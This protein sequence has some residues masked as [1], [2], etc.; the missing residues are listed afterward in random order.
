MNRLHAFEKLPLTPEDDLFSRHPPPSEVV[1]IPLEDLGKNDF[2]VAVVGAGPAG[3]TAALILAGAGY[4]VFMADGAV[5]PR[6]KTCGDGLVRDSMECLKRAGLLEWLDE[7]AFS[8]RYLS[9]TSRKGTTATGGA[10]TRVLQRKILDAKLADT[11]VKRG[12]VFARGRV[13]S[14]SGDKGGVAL[15][16]SGSGATVRA[17]YA[18]VATGTSFDLALKSGLAQKAPVYGAAMRCYVRSKME[19]STLRVVLCGGKT[20]GY[21][22]VFPMGNGIFNIGIGHASRI[23][24]SRKL[25]L[26]SE[27]GIFLETLPDAEELLSTADARTPLLGHPVR[28]ALRG[29]PPLLGER[30]IAT[31]ETIGTTFP[32]SGEGI[33][34][35]MESAELAAKAVL[36]ALE[37]DD[38]ARLKSYPHEID[39]KLRPKYK[40]YLIAEKW[41][42]SPWRN[43]LFIRLAK[44]SGGLRRRVKSVIEE[45]VEPHHVF[46][47]KGIFRS[48]LGK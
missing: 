15:G 3:S 12:A 46:S 23:S 2:D 10:V 22:W 16:F 33:G 44:K 13:S 34:K 6:N 48:L 28:C 21:G 9:L 36:S 45:T 17:R 41:L 47:V 25:N 5:F 19:S 38:P 18:I 29:A 24:H 35:A 31:G 30:I 43:E 42:S 39:A 1:Q 8:A 7:T 20:P 14:L 32:F 40:G 37:A 11:A 27:F 26:H 4:R